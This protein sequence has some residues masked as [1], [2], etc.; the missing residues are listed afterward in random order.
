MADYANLIAVKAILG[1]DDTTEDARLAELNTVASAQLDEKAGLADGESFGVDGTDVERTFLPPP[2]TEVLL[3]L[4]PLRV[5]TSVTADGMALEQ[6]THYEPVYCRGKVWQGL[7]RFMDA[8]NAS[9]VNVNNP[10]D[11]VVP[12]L[13][14]SGT[15]VVTGLWADQGT[16]PLDPVVVEAANVLVAGYWRKDQTADGDVGGSDTQQFTQGD[17][18][19][20]PRVVRFL[21]E[22][23]SWQHG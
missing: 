8:A 21:E 17:P 15:V 22:Y 16:A 19:K 12:P 4:P 11:P 5:L 9:A 10:Y 6:G 1:L 2:W 3:M 18:W 20:D 13:G 23:A 7:Y 14:W